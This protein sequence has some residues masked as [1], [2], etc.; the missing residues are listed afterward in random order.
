MITYIIMETISLLCFLSNSKVLLLLL[1]L[2]TSAGEELK[3]ITFQLQLSMIGIP[4]LSA[5]GLVF[6]IDVALTGHRESML[7]RT[8]YMVSRRNSICVIS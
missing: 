5:A 6:G 2:S 3:H 4:N 8:G 1:I 7:T